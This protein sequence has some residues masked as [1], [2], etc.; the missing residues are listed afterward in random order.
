MLDKLTKRAFS[1]HLHTNFHV[2]LQ[3][4]PPLVLELFQV[5]EGRSTPTLEQF[6]LFFRGPQDPILSQGVFQLEHD[7][8]GTF[9]LFLVPIGPDQ[10]GMRYEAAFNRFV[11]QGQ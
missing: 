2:R 8:M 9:P 7:T 5:A 4:R 10:E 11:K 1:G 6:S 3:G